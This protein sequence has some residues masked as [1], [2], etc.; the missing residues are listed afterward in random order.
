[1]RNGIDSIFGRGTSDLV[2]TPYFIPHGFDKN[3][4]ET[5]ARSLAKTPYF[6]PSIFDKTGKHHPLNAAGNFCQSDR[7][8]L[9]KKPY[10]IP[11]K[12]Y[13]IPSKPYIIPSK[14]Y[15]IPKTGYKPM[16]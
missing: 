1:M 8:S 4:R 15:I 2:K 10:I 5:T 9:P 12:P 7:T 3:A 16:I 13:I 14:P 6:I 11:S